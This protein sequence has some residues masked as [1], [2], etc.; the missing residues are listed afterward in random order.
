M[1]IPSRTFGRKFELSINIPPYNNLVDNVIDCLEC[2]EI[3]VFEPNDKEIFNCNPDDIEILWY[4]KQ[5][6][7]LSVQ[8]RDW[9]CIVCQSIRWMDKEWDYDSKNDLVYAFYKRNAFDVIFPMF[10]TGTPMGPGAYIG[11]MIFNQERIFSDH[12][13]KLHFGAV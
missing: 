11:Q 7:S 4:I 12:D 10:D 9:L 3:L 5:K 13:G 2:D 6:A 8:I 1:S